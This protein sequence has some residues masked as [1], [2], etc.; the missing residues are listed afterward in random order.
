MSTDY[1]FLSLQGSSHLAL[2]IDGKATVLREMGNQTDVN[3]AIESDTYAINESKTGKRQKVLEQTKS[4]G[5][6][7]E[8]K[9]NEQKK[10]DVALMFQANTIT[11]DSKTV[12]GET[13]TT[14]KAGDEIKLAGF[15]LTDVVIKDSTATP[16]TLVENTHYS[17]DA[18]F[19]TIKLL[20]VSGV[21]QPLKVDYTQGG[22]TSSVLFSLPDGADYYYLFKGIN[23]INDKH[24]SVELWRFKPAVTGNMGFINEENGEVSI[25]GSALADTTKQQDPKLGGFGRLVYLD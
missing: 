21:T 20:S 23:S 18:K 22:V 16:V 1:E 13:L 9:L 25:Q 11:T 4:R 2:N 5:V 17:L 8:I 14:L 19:G 10:E 6:K 12:T 24:L 15:N 7:L 3:L